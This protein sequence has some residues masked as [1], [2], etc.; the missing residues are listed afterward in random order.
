M[1]ILIVDDEKICRRV[2]KETLSLIGDCV[3][4]NNSKDALLFFSTALDKKEPFD[5]ITID[6][7]MP[8]MSGEALLEEI[9]RRERNLDIPKAGRSKIIMV[10][11]RMDIGTIKNCIKLGCNSYIAKPV[12]KQEL[13]L[14]LE[15]LDISI[16]EDFKV[17]NGTIHKDAMKELIH[18]FNGGKIEMPVLPHIVQEIRDL[19][20]SPTPSIEA[21]AVIIEK[22]AVMSTKLISIANSPLYM[23][24][25]KV[26]SVNGALLRLGMEETQSVV[27]TV[28]NKNLYKSDNK[29]SQELLKKLWL[30]SFACAVCGKLIAGELGLQNLE[31]IFLMGIIH[32]IGKVLLIQAIE[33]ISPGEAFD[34]IDLQIAI[35]QIHTV[36]GAVLIKK[37]RFPEEFINVV[38]NHH[39]N[40]FPEETAKEL[41]VIQLADVLSYMIGYGFYD[42]DRISMQSIDED[43]EE[44]VIDDK[45][46]GIEDRESFKKLGIDIDKLV[47]IGEKAK[48]II[49]D[50]AKVF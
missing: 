22:D 33:D 47:L 18:R 9:R 8:F 44:Q 16:P 43:E 27:S 42:M 32:D 31:N 46:S 48:E 39:W 19:L 6:I 45:G 23:G 1:K 11:S 24:T 38:E 15:K 12:Y 3:V 28:V 41:L 21:L 7:S 4:A 20:D 30:H 26:I 50:S 17:K 37:W 2:L 10:T 49:K 34:K 13:F 29:D 40:D 36:F 35:H 5:L 25:D 14:H